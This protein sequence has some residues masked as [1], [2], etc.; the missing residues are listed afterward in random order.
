MNPEEARTVFAHKEFS[1]D[2][3]ILFKGSLL[4]TEETLPSND[5]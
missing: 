5:S 4:D 3:G 2:N 1:R